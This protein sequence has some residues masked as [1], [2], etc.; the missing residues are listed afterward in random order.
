MGNYQ[1]RQREKYWQKYWQRGK[2]FDFNPKAKGKIYAIDTPPPT[3]SGQLHLGHVFSY[4]QAEIIAAYRRMAGF[5]LRYPIGFDNNGL[6]TEKLTEKET[7][8]DPRQTDLKTFIKACLTVIARYQPDYRNL[9]RRL[10]FRWSQNLE[11]STISPKVQKL[12]QETFLNLYRRGEIYR[13]KTPVLYCP[14]CQTSVAQAEVED[15]ERPGVFYD[16]IFRQKD[17]RE[18][19]IATTRPELLPAIAAV[20]VHPDDR[21]YRQLVGET[22]TSPLGDRVKV[23]ADTKVDPQKGSGAVMCC[24]YGDS[25]DVYWAKT[26]HLKENIIIANDGTINKNAKIPE[27]IGKAIDEAR[28]ILVEKLK[29]KGAIKGEKAI[30]HNVGVHE[31]C[32]TPIEIIPQ[33]QWFIKILAHRQE[34]IQYGDKIN[35]HPA[36][37]K[38]RYQDWV[39]GLKWDWC[40]S[41][42]RFFG[43]PV[44]VYHCSHCHK[45]IL[46]DDKDLPIDPRQQKRRCPYCGHRLQ[47]D[48][49]VLDTWFTS[50]LTPDINNQH[51]GNGPQQGKL[52]PLSL[53]PQGHDIIRTWATYSIL[54]GL[55]NHQSPPWKDIM[56]SGHILAKKGEKISK[57]TGGGQYRPQDLIDKYSADALRYAMAGASLGLDAYFEEK[58]VEKGQRLI[59]KLYHAGKFVI[60]NLNKSYQPAALNFS[61]LEA[62]DQWILFRSQQTAR[63][64]ANYLNKF[65]Y[66]QAL[67]AF[68]KFFWH[69]FCDNYL[70]ISKERVYGRA[71]SQKDSAQFS[72]YHSYLAILIMIAPFLP[73]I[74]EELYHGYLAGS[75][76]KKELASCQG[77]GV[78]AN[79]EKIASIHLN[80]WPKSGNR[81]PAG[82]AAAA[83]TALGII[84]KV[85]AAK[86]GRQ[87]SLSQPV[88]QLNISAPAELWQNLQPFLKDL[89]SV[90]KSRQISHRPAEKFSLIISF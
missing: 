63:T 17:N 25:T 76:K 46:P 40:I 8:L 29:K 24:T 39:K 5:N 62:F 55:L 71:G 32:S 79:N 49:N 42:G 89:A 36:K 13:Q 31:R 2:F 43:I 72:L 7:G 75:S 66:H 52:Y 86:S 85:R 51:P 57:K 27:I 53:R 90:T 44:P 16:L 59:T 50:A 73:H 65:R 28:E 1:F 88:S 54:M 67:M 23:I 70:E 80:P 77:R 83:E 26:Y 19:I 78:F 30:R 47:A 68:E 74:S 61:Q 64:M 22:V 11:Y 14:Q 58:E 10:G 18:L 35:W 56:V 34:M 82:A 41:R 87:L 84:E 3:I 45:I 20:F 12:S 37:M 60:S 38:R 21:R 9:F 81:L 6:P 69:D 4:T 33:P 48:N 15:K